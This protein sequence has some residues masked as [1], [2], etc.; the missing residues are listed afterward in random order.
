MSL[1]HGGK[2]EALARICVAPQ[3]MA[4]Q[5][6]RFVTRLEL[7][8][9]FVRI[10]S[11]NTPEE[12]SRRHRQPFS[13]GS[14]ARS[15]RQDCKRTRGQFSPIQRCVAASAE[16]GSRAQLDISSCRVLRGHGEVL[17]GLPRGTVRSLVKPVLICQQ[18]L[19]QQPTL[20]CGLQRTTRGDRTRAV[21]STGTCIA[22]T[23]Q[24]CLIHVL[25]WDVR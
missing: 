5:Y 14:S 25:H 10:D 20:S 15:D 3:S 4:Q 13:Y 12:I 19:E 11:L 24:R 21:S 9:A 1:G 23:I 8:A 7:H 2:G 17:C 22:N 18:N 16:R 6:Q